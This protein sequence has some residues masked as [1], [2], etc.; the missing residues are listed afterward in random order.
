MNVTY[1]ETGEEMMKALYQKSEIW[2]A[3]VWIIAY[4]VL[5]SIGD[6]LSVNIGTQKIVTLP[7]L[8]VLS[9]ILFLFVC[10]NFL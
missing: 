7:I 9:A 8:I 10:N 1:S 6:S 2:F 5:A 4:C 3:I